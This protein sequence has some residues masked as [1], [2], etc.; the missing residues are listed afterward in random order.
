[1]G[2]YIND[3]ATIR[4]ILNSYVIY[5]FRSKKE[6]SDILA[7]TQRTIYNNDQIFK[8]LLG[9]NSL[10]SCGDKTVI[11]IDSDR[12][13][14][15]LNQLSFIYKLHSYNPDDMVLYFLILQLLNGKSCTVKELAEEL[16]NYFIDGIDCRRVENCLEKEMLPYGIIHIK[17][18]VISLS[19]TICDAA[20]GKD[21]ERL[22]E[23]YYACGLYECHSV[24]GVAGS[25]LCDI[26]SGT[27][28]NEHVKYKDGDFIDERGLSEVHKV[29]IF[30]KNYQNTMLNNDIAFVLMDAVRNRYV[31][32]IKYDDDSYIPDIIP[33]K[34][35]SEFM[36]GR[37]FIA[38]ITRDSQVIIRRIDRI[39][40]VETE[41]A[42][43]EP[44]ISVFNE[45]MSKVWC[46][47]QPDRN[48]QCGTLRMDIYAEHELDKMLLDAGNLGA[49]TVT[50]NGCCR[51]EAESSDIRELVPWIRS[52]GKSAVIDAE[53]TDEQLYGYIKNDWKK[54]LENYGQ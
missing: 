7:K 42:G 20:G 50:E 52:F 40:S 2:Y 22:A 44:D 18:N 48:K 35:I 21:R 47:S 11:K 12:M 33:L 17:D 8:D 27:L 29:F 19:E 23:L 39:D 1:M 31:I 32:R 16:E 26:I 5:S 51:F 53:H 4:K 49:V 54:A 3:L 38:G 25:Y 37:Q 43:F 28:I 6:I 45:K 46:A 9:E 15:D 13:N 24:F 36:S 41:R 10:E 30:Q 34:L 14:V